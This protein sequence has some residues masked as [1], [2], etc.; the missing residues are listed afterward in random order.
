MGLVL[1]DDGRVSGTYSALIRP[2][3]NTYDGFNT[4]LHGIGPADT[5]DSPKFI[6]VLDEALALIGDRPILAHYAAF[7]LGVIRAECVAAGRPW[8]SVTVGCTLV[9]SRRCWPGLDSYSLPIVADFLD[10]PAFAHHDVSADARACAEIARALLVHTGSHC[11]PDAAQAV[12]VHLGRLEPLT[13]AACLA[14]QQHGGGSGVSKKSITRSEGVE[15]DP[16][17]PFAE[18]GVSFT[19]TLLSMTR[20]SAAQSVVDNG[21]EFTPSPGRHTD[22]LVMGFQDFTRFVDGESS[23]KTKK[24]RQLIAGGYPLQI[25][26]EDEFLK[27]LPAAT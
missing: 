4:M 25:I 1:V 6:E 9:L 24:A 23:S 16:D 14:I 12:G 11:I 2:P 13:Y 22:Y 15:V 5:A 10:L 8:P 26:G 19:G 20:R 7:D 18:A 27:M 3:E 17:N 21:G